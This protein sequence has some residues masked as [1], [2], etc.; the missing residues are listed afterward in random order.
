MK[1]FIVATRCFALALSLASILGGALKS[2][3]SLTPLTPPDLPHLSPFHPVGH[4]TR[5]GSVTGH[6][7]AVAPG[8]GG[9]QG[10]EGSY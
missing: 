6:V 4:L 9:E 8:A 2:L 1:G 5:H 10:R 3:K 7:Q